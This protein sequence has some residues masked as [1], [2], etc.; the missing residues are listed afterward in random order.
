MRKIKHFPSWAFVQLIRH[1]KRPK[2]S[3]FCYHIYF[4]K[5]C[6]SFAILLVRDK[7]T[8]NLLKVLLT[9]VP[10]FSLLLNGFFQAKI[11]NLYALF[12]SILVAGQRDPY[13]QAKVQCHEE[14]QRECF[15]LFFISMFYKHWEG[16]V[17]ERLL[18]ERFVGS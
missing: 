5:F 12:S 2:C 15:C 7:G 14:N 18:L 17:N 1:A 3:N 13:L 6:G 16:E 10:L 8:L 4:V 11:E 9:E